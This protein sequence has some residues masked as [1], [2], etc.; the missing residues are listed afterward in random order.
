[1]TL[2]ALIV[3]RGI[4]SGIESACKILMPLLIVLIIVLAVYSIGHGDLHSAVQFLFRIDPT[5]VGP[6][7][8]LEAFGL[9]FFLSVWVSPS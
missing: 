6:K 1:M 2:T 9:S 5:S 4:A 3:G 8:A 7:V